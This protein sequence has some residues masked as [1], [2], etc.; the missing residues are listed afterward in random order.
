MWGNYAL[1]LYRNLSR[2][3]LYAGINVLGLALGIAVF[4][5]LALVVRFETSFDRWIPGAQD[6]YRLNAIQNWPGQVRREHPVH[7]VPRFPDLLAR[8]PP[9]HGGHPAI[10]PAR[11]GSTV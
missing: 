5:V 6:I 4:G 7:H 10:P 1:S 9:I 11:I 3:W 2:R 8:V